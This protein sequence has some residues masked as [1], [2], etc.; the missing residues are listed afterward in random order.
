MPAVDLCSTVFLIRP[1]GLFTPRKFLGRMAHKLFLSMLDQADLKPLANRLHDQSD[2]LPFSVSELFPNGAQHFWMRVAGL[3]PQMSLVLRTQLGA[4]M[5]QTIHVEPRDQVDETQW[6]CTVDAVIPS[7]HEWA[8]SQTYSEFIGSAWHIPRQR[9]MRLEFVTPTAVKSVGMYRPFPLPHWIFRPL[10][11][12]LLR[13]DTLTL[14]YQPDPAYLE[15]YAE[16][17]MS[18]QDYELRCISGLPMKDESLVAFKG[19]VDYRLLSANEDFEKSTR[20]VGRLYRDV[21]AATVYSDIQHHRE[22]YACLLHLLAQ[23]AFYSGVG[24]YTGQGMGMVQ[25]NERAGQ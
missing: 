20:K 5:G 9:R 6:E 14:P 2:R 17:F 21:P 1:H 10:Y 24:R 25:I 12:R 18:I 13:L 3:T 15:A 4:L 23:F 22:Q 19:W 8:R 16:H 7:Q 11:E